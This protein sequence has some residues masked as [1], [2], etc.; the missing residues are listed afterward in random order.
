MTVWPNKLTF[1][2]ADSTAAMSSSVGSRDL[3][4]LLYTLSV[5]MEKLDNAVM[6]KW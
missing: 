2:T 3:I 6:N 1:N 5:V 4:S